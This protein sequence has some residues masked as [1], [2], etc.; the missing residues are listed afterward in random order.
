MAFD[1]EQMT[2]DYKK[3]LR[4]VPTQRN[5]LAQ[6]GAIN[7]IISALT[8]GQLVNLFPR[9]YRDQLPDVGK[10]NRYASKLDVALSG[11]PL[12]SKSSGGVT[13]YGNAPSPGLKKTLTPEE[14]AI[15]EIFQEAKVGQ[16]DN[17]P[18]GKVGLYRPSYTLT[19]ADLSDE[20]V[21]TIAGEAYLSSKEGVD[22]VINVMLNRVGSDQYGANLLAVASQGQGT[23]GIQFEG[24]NKGKVTPE[25]AEYIR[26]RIRVLASGAEP[27]N[28][29]G[30]NEFRQDDYV[31]GEGR[32]KPFYRDAEAQGFINI[33]GNIF[34][35]RG[36]YDGPYQG[37]D[38]Q[39]MEARI[40]EVEAAA[41]K[42]QDL[43]TVIQKFDP[44]QI[45][46]LD[47][48]LQKWYENAS[49]TQKKKFETALERLGTDKF[50][51]VMKKQPLNSPTLEAIT[52][53]PLPSSRVTEQQAGYRKLPI[54]PELKNALEY[55][56]EKSGLEVRIFSGGQ[57]K[58]IHDAMEAAGKNSAWRHSVDIEGIPGAADVVLYRRNENDN[59]VPLSVTDPSHSD[60]IATFTENFSRVTP[61]AGI[62]VNYMKTGNKV[63]PTLIHYGGPNQPGAPPARWG[64]VPDYIK[65]AHLR[66]ITLR[67]SDVKA[68]VDPLA[69]W[70]KQK[71][72][73][74]AELI[75]KEAEAKIGAS[76]VS[77][78]GAKQEEIQ[79]NTAPALATGGLVDVPPGEN[80]RIQK[81]NG[82]IL[83]YANDRENIRVEPGELEGSKQYPMPTQE[84]VQQL[85]TKIQKPDR[86]GYNTQSDPN[87]YTDMAEGFAPVPPSQ[88]R[89][90][91][92]ARLYGDD[93]YRMINSHFE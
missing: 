11:A 78:A 7:D 10:I 34:A 80:V 84:Q 71:Q 61:S 39:E 41:D 36:N 70:I 56:A 20:V 31:Y 77:A 87:L 6:S 22:A 49:E 93:S 28:T 55:A 81:D 19:E 8:P 35:A 27:D 26:E 66:G 32:G 83:A 33:G 53:T 90:T 73:Q 62:G 60:S 42:V 40:A 72:E 38:K 59:L 46:Q 9:Y 4:L 1:L 43:E 88:L 86:L 67:D 30:A 13:S 51:E 79:A 54:K 16:F 23:S 68:G 91:N 12:A 48:R 69:E 21:R 57:D 92:R 24:Y 14:K 44:S 63:D 18:K 75:K 37:Y 65:E 25:Q 89:A 47:E 3:L 58:D 29:F 2:V 50:N 76:P 85:E 17:L 82:E 64:N 45:G 5:Q 74:Q 52:A 15:Q